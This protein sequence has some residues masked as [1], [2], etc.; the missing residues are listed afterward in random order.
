MVPEKE[1]TLRQIRLI[2]VAYLF[3]SLVIW[4]IAALFIK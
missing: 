1:L 3:V 2:G 4:L